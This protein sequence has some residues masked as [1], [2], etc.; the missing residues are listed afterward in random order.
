MSMPEPGPRM[1]EVESRLFQKIVVTPD[2][3]QVLEQFAETE[4][5]D[6]N[7]ATRTITVRGFILCSCGHY[8]H[9]SEP[10]GECERCRAEGRNPVACQLCFCQCS[11]SGC[12]TTGLCLRHSFEIED[13]PKVK[14]RVC[15]E[16]HEKR[17]RAERI[18]LF[19]W[20]LFLPITIPLVILRF[21]FFKP[22]K[23]EDERQDERL[24]VHPNQP[25]VRLHP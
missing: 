13:P 6:G 18:R 22:M 11:E 3:P 7:E 8:S 21:I 4:F 15:R 12:G 24:R 2:G 19:L 20:L 16:H 9:V 25:T 10:T 14:R 17:K 23:R 1:E 5:E